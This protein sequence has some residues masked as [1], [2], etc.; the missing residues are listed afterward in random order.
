MFSIETVA[1]VKFSTGKAGSMP[2]VVTNAEETA[3]SQLEGSRNMI[4]QW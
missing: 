4:V 1:S 2:L 3:G